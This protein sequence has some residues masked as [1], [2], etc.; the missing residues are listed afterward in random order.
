MMQLKLIALCGGAALLV[1]SLGGCGKTSRQLGYAKLQIAEQE[2]QIAEQ[3]ALLAAQAAELDELRRRGV[4]PG[5]VGAPTPIT[6]SD[7]EIG[8]GW[9]GKDHVL[10]ISNELL[11]KPG[12][13]VLS[14]TAKRVLDKAIAMMN[15]Q[16]KGDQ[17]RVEGHTDNQPIKRSKD[18][19]ED[20]WDLSGGR[21][22]AVLRYLQDHGIAAKQLGFAGYGMEKPVGPNGS[23]AAM[24]KN[25]RVE[26]V[27]ITGTAGK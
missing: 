4:Q 23:P 12:S 3:E 15:A 10:T 24:A 19:W 16:H 25:R 1:L 5:P 11:F 13:A 2:R 20:N 6:R 18:K 14:D 9:R 8:E 21:A 22:L 7:G 27:V 17:V 26:I